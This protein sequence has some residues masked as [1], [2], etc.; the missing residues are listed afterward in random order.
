MA[1]V[2]SALMPVSDDFR[3]F[4][5]DTFMETLHQL[6]NCLIDSFQSV[7]FSIISIEPTKDSSDLI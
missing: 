6:L 4:G 2:D 7:D 5:R 3:W 1:K